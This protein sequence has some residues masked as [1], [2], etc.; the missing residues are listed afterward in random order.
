MSIRT[1]W[2]RVAAAFAGVAL[3]L[4]VPAMARAAESPAALA[5]A[6]ELARRR[7]RGLGFLGGLGALCCLAVVV[8]IVLVV[9]LMMRRRR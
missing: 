5:V 4:V 2:G 3:A 8:V 1:L 9:V 7:P 6:D